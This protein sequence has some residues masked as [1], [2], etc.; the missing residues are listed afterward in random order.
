MYIATA[1][2][3]VISIIAFAVVRRK[4]LVEW[5]VCVCAEAEMTYG[6]GT[7][8]LKLRDV[9]S[10]FVKVYQFCNTI[11]RTTHSQYNKRYSSSSKRIGQ[12]HQTCQKNQHRH[13][14]IAERNHGKATHIEQTGYLTDTGK[15]QHDSLHIHQDAHKESG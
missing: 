8:Y 5:L 12:H 2:L 1:I 13:Y 9:Y 3:L 7:G 14:I 11:G 15:Y 10:E 6:S 4:N